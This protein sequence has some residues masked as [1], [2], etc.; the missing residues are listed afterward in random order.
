MEID[1]RLSERLDS[2]KDYGPDDPNWVA[3][4]RDH[5]KYLKRN[6]PVTHF[7]PEELVKYRY[8][9]QEFYV[10]KCYG[11]FSQTWVFLFV[12]DIRNPSDFNENCSKLYMV[13]HDKIEELFNI[14]ST[15]EN[16]TR[17]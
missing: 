4:I 6:S 3:F 1:Q 16:R 13:P 9:P 15:S 12:N 5:K 14:Y 11:K 2:L 17:D 10:D 8:R 7:R